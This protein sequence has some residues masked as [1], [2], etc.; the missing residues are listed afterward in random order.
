M[1][2]AES[3]RAEQLLSEA[4]LARTAMER[5]ISETTKLQE[6]ALKVAEQSFAPWSARMTLAVEKMGRPISA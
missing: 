5:T 3:R 6:T 2:P 4:G 1:P